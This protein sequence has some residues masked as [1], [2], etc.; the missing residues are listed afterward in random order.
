MEAVLV[1]TFHA[2]NL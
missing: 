1:H 2:Y